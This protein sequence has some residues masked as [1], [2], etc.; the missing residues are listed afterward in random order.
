MTVTVESVEAAAM[1]LPESDRI[2][3]AHRL[4][5]SVA[6]MTPEIETAWLDEVERR[7]VE[8][9]AGTGELAVGDDVIRELRRTT[10]GGRI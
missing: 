3:L 6:H 1:E 4:A 5:R 2:H 8:V 7:L 10:R 9:D